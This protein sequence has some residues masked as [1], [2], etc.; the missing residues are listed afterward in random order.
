ML[1]S[2]LPLLSITI[3][4]PIISGILLLIIG[5]INYKI[6]KLLALS[7][8]IIVFL[9]STSFYLNFDSETANMQ[10]QEYISWIAVINSNYHIGIDGFSMPLVLLTTFMHLLVII[11][12]LSKQQRINLYMSMFLIME[13]L[14]IGVFTALD[15][16]LFYVFF[17]AML[18]PMFIIIGIW[19]GPK[20]VYATFKF[21]IYTFSGSL[22]M[23]VALLYM[24]DKANS[25]EISELHKLTLN[26]SEQTF[27]F[28]ALLLGF[29]VKVPT[30][31]FHTWLPDAHV[32]APTEGSI[33]L[34]AIT[35]KI[36]GYGFLRFIL[37]I[38]PDA[39]ANLSWL[40]IAISLIAIVYIGLIALVQKDM[41]K[42]IAYSS[43]AHMGFVTLGIFIIFP[44]YDHMVTAVTSIEGSLIQM[45]SHGFVSGALFMCIGIL[46]DRM[47]SRK[48]DDYGGIV[49]SM[50][51][52]ATF[53]VIFSMANIGL[54]GTSGFVG[55]FMIIISSFNTSFWVAFIAS[56]TLILSAAYTL[57]LVKR[58]VFGNPKNRYIA[59]LKDT[60]FREMFILL[61]ITLFILA[62]GIC[63]NIILSKTHTTVNEF[64]KSSILTKN[65]F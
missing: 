47:H 48:I 21:F 14:I 41:K 8:A 9:I 28:F 19:G 63:P 20:K 58:L 12:I 42:L 38:V 61:I 57:F 7:V 62:I 13:G 33:I 49:N 18:I 35:L 3:W 40:I 39:S 54:P 15:S 64:L 46:Y 37:P 53:F 6:T 52:F 55:E 36:G 25:F 22:F 1:L 44:T 11:N 10:F 5:E 29:A 51:I 50:P 31:P 60:D 16:L 27:I 17:E 43:V 32:E 65:Y 23:L 59:E 30:W 45:I 4:L 26:I 2:E 34:A 24:Y 56:L